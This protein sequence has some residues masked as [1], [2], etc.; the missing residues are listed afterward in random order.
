MLALRGGSMELGARI[1]CARCII[2]QSLAVCKF[3]TK[4]LFFEKVLLGSLDE[5][6]SHHI[7]IFFARGN[8]L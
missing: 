3:L 6:S 7:D 1:A 2:E 8:S 5:G 4:G